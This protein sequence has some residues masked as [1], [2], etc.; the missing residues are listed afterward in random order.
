[1][2]L[3][4]R[5]RHYRWYK[6]D[7]VSDYL[8]LD[9]HR[10]IAPHATADVQRYAGSWQWLRDGRQIA[11]LVYIILPGRRAVELRYNYRGQPVEPYLV[12]WSIS[13]PHYGGQ[14]YWWLCPRCG[15][16]CAHLY[17]G[18]P[19][20]CRR[21]Q[22]LTYASAQ[23]GDP[24]RERAERRMIQIR[25][26]LGADAGLINPLP[27]KPPHMHWATYYK[28]LREYEQLQVISW[29]E[30]ALLLGLGGE[31]DLAYLVDHTWSEYQRGQ[32]PEPPTAEEIAALLAE[33][34]PAAEP[35]ARR[36]PARRTLGQI[37]KVAAVPVDFAREA[38]AEGLLR[39][40]AGRSTRRKRYRTKVASWLLKLHRL[41]QA[42]C[43]WPELR[44]WAARRFTPGH[45]HE[46]RWPAGYDPDPAAPIVKSVQFQGAAAREVAASP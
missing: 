39:P 44:A 10:M 42:G 6:K 1:M 26:R 41:R 16:R 31:Q 17:G 29:G 12:H 32:A 4:G 15:Q 36:R 19:F 2:G 28:L 38:Q 24:R 20:L 40:D 18:H 27:D 30:M 43:T 34:Q 7:L 9:A 13:Y 5:G 33:V 21:C 25:R 45:E 3:D 35:P 11:S 46:R 37:A 22:G 8:R 23:S 14:R